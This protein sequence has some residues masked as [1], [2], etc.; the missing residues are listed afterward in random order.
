MTS[1]KLVP[2][3][4]EMWD[5]AVV[6]SS[7]AA[8]QPGTRSKS[9]AEPGCHCHRCPCSCSPELQRHHQSMQG[10][11]HRQE[12]LGSKKQ[13]L[14]D[15]AQWERV[16]LHN[17]SGISGGVFQICS[18]KVCGTRFV[19]DPNFFHCISGFCISP[20]LKSHFRK[21]KVLTSDLALR[22]SEER[23]L[24]SHR[25]N[26]LAKDIAPSLTE[27]RGDWMQT[28]YALG[29]RTLLG[30]KRKIALLVSEH[31]CITLHKPVWL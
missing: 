12:K 18:E 17:E 31:C 30:I 1:A 9:S 11:I 21:K 14:S 2:G 10:C 16:V 3:V 20:V 19:S 26:S 29:N 15:R 13:M 7:R 23:C 25:E 27:Y 24:W 28:H 8:C 5:A 4:P 22:Y 6:P